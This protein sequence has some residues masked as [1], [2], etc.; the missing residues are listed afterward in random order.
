M[1]EEMGMSGGFCKVV[2]LIFE[3]NRI[4]LNALFM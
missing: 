1:E 4:K 2:Y 3:L